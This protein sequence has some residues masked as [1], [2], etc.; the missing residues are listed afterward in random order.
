M[1]P[2]FFK[3]IVV[4]PVETEYLKKYVFWEFA[5]SHPWMESQLV[6]NA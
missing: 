4:V 5:D 1:P 3:V 2:L 6:C